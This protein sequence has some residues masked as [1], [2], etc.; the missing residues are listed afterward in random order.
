MKLIKNL[1]K[2]TF[3]AIAV[4]LGMRIYRDKEQNTPHKPKLKPRSSVKLKPKSS[5]TTKKTNTP[6]VA[7]NGELNDRQSK[8]L[9]LIREKGKAEMNDFRSEFSSV[10]PRTLRRDL[11]KLEELNLVAKQGKTKS[12]RYIAK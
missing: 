2:L 11:N 5:A 7:A 6:L 8:L 9:L 1:F 3:F 10:T 4:V 12:A